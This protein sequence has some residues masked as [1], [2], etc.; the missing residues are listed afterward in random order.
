MSVA[1][2]PRCSLRAVRHIQSLNATRI[3]LLWRERKHL[4]EHFPN[5]A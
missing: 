2:L 5:S 4:K 1:H 3:R